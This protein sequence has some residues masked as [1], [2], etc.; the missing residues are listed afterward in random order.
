MTETPIDQLDKALNQFWKYTLP[1][2][3]YKNIQSF[4][5]FSH[6]VKD[7]S[8]EVVNRKGETLKESYEKHQLKYINHFSKKYHEQVTNFLKDK[9]NTPEKTK[10]L[11]KK[12]DANKMT[13]EKL[14]SIYTPLHHEEQPS[15][16]KRQKQ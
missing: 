7:H 16:M 12:Y 10:K 15:N 1:T 8:H 11:L 9:S 13:L 4:R 14:V 2:K 5:L 3:Y 6:V